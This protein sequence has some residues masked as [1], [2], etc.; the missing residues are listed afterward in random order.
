MKKSLLSIFSVALCAGLATNTS[1]Q[2]FTENFNG[3]PAIPANWVMINGDSKIPSNQLNAAIVTKLTTQAWMGWPRAAGDSCALTVSY[4]SSPAKADRWLI[5]PSFMVTDPNMFITWEDYSSDAT[6]TDSIQV[7]VSPT[8]GTTAASFTATLYNN[9]GSVSGFTK[10]GV[11]LA[12]YNGTN[13]RV[14]FRNNSTDQY[15]L[16]ID[17][18]AAQILPTSDLELTNVTPTLGSPLAYETAGNSVTLGGTVTNLGANPVTSYVVKYQ[19]GANPVVSQTITGVNIA[20]F[21]THTFSLTTPYTLPATIGDYGIKMWVELPGDAVAT[22]DSMSTMASTVAFK[23]AKRILVEEGTGTWCGFCPRGSVYMDSLWNAHHNN[24]SLVAVHNAD[25][26]EVPA[27][28]ALISSKIPG[29]PAVYIDRREVLDPADLIDVYNEQKDYFGFA[30]ITL[31][32]QTITGNTLSLPVTVK[33]AVDLNGD[34][35]LALVITEN[36]VSGTSSGYAQVNYYDGGA[37]GPL[38]GAGLDWETAGDPVPASVMSYDFVA[39][40]IVPDELGGV[41][42]LPA[43]MTYNNTYNYTFT[44]PVSPSWNQNKLYAVVMLIRASDGVVL[45]SNNKLPDATGISNVSAGLTE[46]NVYPNPAKDYAN[47]TFGLTDASPVQIQLINAVG[48][49]VYTSEKKL[50]AGSQSLTVPTGN[51]ASGIYNIK[52]QTEKGSLTQRL[53]VIK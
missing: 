31:G 27:Y 19:Q 9:K 44:A 4:F 20:L 38:K 29:Y 18:V 14:A 45:N 34:Y 26:M 32:N 33:P 41:G 39:R 13:I 42:T 28:D 23:P 5:T 24:F 11:S 48:Q 49:V 47:I 8:A 12:A 16:R 37:Y 50:A 22:N 52:V 21:S 10:K 46:M 15:V 35:R 7:L 17:N 43:T 40:A 36:N 3:S 1:A 6:Y 25:P 53:S 30:E 2:P 51:V